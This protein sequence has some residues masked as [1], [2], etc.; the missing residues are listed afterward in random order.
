MKA[1]GA[2]ERSAS[3]PAAGL[4]ARHHLAAAG[5]RQRMP[6]KQRACSGPG[7]GQRPNPHLRVA[8]MS[9]LLEHRVRQSGSL[10]KPAS[11]RSGRL[12]ARAQLPVIGWRKIALFHL[13]STNATA[14]SI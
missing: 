4:Q 6:H 2:V 11:G 5:R 9:L 13:A 12:S 14:M 7:G 3:G 1:R 10:P 8:R